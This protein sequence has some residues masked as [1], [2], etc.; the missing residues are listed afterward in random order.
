MKKILHCFS[1][2]VLVGGTATLARAGI[3]F[4]NPINDSGLASYSGQTIVYGVNT[5][6]TIVGAAKAGGTALDN[7]NGFTSPSPYST[8]TPVFCS[9]SPCSGQ[10]GVS[11]PNASI[12]AGINDAGN[13]IV[14]SYD[15]GTSI[16]SDVGGFIDTAGTFTN[17]V[18][19]SVT[20][21]ACTG[22]NTP[23]GSIPETFIQGISAT[24]GE[25]VGFYTQTTGTEAYTDSGGVLSL[26]TIAGTYDQA[27]AVNDSG[28]VAGIICTSAGSGTVTAA[29]CAGNANQ[30]G[31]VKNGATITCYDGNG[32]APSN[33]TACNGGFVSLGIT[34][35]QTIVITGIDNAGDIVGYYTQGGF[36]YGFIDNFGG[37]SGLAAGVTTLSDQGTGPQVGGTNPGF[38]ISGFEGVKI[39]GINSNGTDIVGAYADGSNNLDGF[40]GSFGSSSVPEPGTLLLSFSA[41]GLLA[42]WGRKRRMAKS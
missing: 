26:L 28:V 30:F 4:T 8:F 13:V 5:S 2:L 22:A 6:G 1:G 32:T 37:I 34:G 12:A 36:Q 10:N 19:T 33:V 35:A 39:F 21:P 38:G 27:N 11:T 3:T 29:G 9:S 15:T 31:F 14:G 17:F 20:C 25:F 16:S 40:L 24:S 7:S 42:V 18:I 23:S 41:L